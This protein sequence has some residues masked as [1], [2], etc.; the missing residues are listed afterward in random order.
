VEYFTFAL[1]QFTGLVTPLGQLVKAFS[2]LT[3]SAASLG[4]A[5]GSISSNVEEAVSLGLPIMTVLM[6]VGVIN[7]SGVDESARKPLVIKLLKMFSPVSAAI[8]ALCIAEY[9]G[10]S[11]EH[12]MVKNLDGTCAISHV[13][14]GWLWFEMVTMF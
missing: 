9:K 10:M 12:I 8:E 2:V 13:W 1:K 7:P 4:F 6:A 3:L 5:V 11:F 14:V